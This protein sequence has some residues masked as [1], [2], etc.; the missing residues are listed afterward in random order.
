LFPDPRLRGSTRAN[1]ANSQ[2]HP[3][4]SILRLL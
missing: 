1:T 2:P 4:L 3:N